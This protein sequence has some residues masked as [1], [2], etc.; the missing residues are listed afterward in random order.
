MSTG[1]RAVSLLGLDPQTY[2]PHTSHDETRAYRETNCWTDV[3]IELVHARGLEPL[4]AMGSTVRGDFEGDQW[5][6]FKPRF[7]EIEALYGIE[8]HEMQQ[9]R[10]LEAQLEEQLRHDRSVLV[11]LDAWFLPDT[12]GLSHGTQHVKTTV[13]VEAIDPDAET[14]R[15]FHNAGYFELSGADY[16]GALRTGEEWGPETL[17]PY[18]EL[19]RFDA[20]PALQGD[21]LR[22]AARRY[23]HHHLQRLP[24]GNPFTRFSAAL[25]ASMDDLAAADPTTR[26]DYVFATVRMIGSTFELLGSHLEWLDADGSTAARE[27]LAALVEDSK[28]LSFRIARRR[29]FDHEPIVDRMAASWDEAMT[30]LQAGRA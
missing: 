2:V 17:P 14:L 24:A 19:V 1:G 8:I 23:T 12:A 26:A 3:Y 13:G 21:E 22:D 27:P 18:T 16:R 20:G 5:T 15:Y 9:Y 11:E 28:L 4:A 29:A 10:S 25:G 6:F 7:D 30:R